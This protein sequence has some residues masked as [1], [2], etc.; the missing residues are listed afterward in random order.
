MSLEKEE[1][2]RVYE[3]ISKA[4]INRT[5][6][7]LSLGG[8]IINL[9]GILNMIENV[10]IPKKS[11]TVRKWITELMKIVEELELKTRTKSLFDQKVI[12]LEFLRSCLDRKSSDYDFAFEIRSNI[13]ELA[14]RDAKEQ[15]SRTKSKKAT[16]GK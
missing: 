16:L 1:F 9:P 7:S 13:L 6:I 15:I 2:Y 4:E 11:K 10:N 8:A 14:F 12:I 3:K 5:R